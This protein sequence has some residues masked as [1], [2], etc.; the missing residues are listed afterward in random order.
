MVVLSERQQRIL[1][2]IR[3]YGEENGYPPTIREIG[4]AVG[5]TSTSVVKYNLERLQEKGCIGRSKEVSRGLRLVENP[6]SA[7]PA[8]SA[9]I[10]GGSRA[11]QVP[12]YGMI[13]AGSPIAAAGQ[14][15]NPYAGEVLALPEELVP[16]SGEIYALRVKGDSMIDA[17]VADGD[18]IVIR[19]QPTAQ[20]KDMIVAWIKDRE[21]TTLKYYYPEGAQ[22]R[23]Q[24]ANPA[25]EPIYVPADNLEIQGKVVAIVRQLAA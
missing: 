7:P 24:P 1:D 23:L 18:W 25:Y 9:A 12:I 3:Q 15:E 22:V 19:H 16:G 2:F 5:I 6:V 10:Y 17:L 8:D 14:Q 11:I 20:T 13:S 4:K 21:E